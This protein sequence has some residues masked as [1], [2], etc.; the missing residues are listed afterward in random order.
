MALASYFDK[1]ALAAA[2]VLQGYDRAAFEARLLATPVE[3]AFD[4][5]ATRLP[6]AQ[7]TL[8]LAVRLLARLYPRL[9]LTALDEAACDYVAILETQARAINTQLDLRPA[10]AVASLVVGCT[11][12]E[13]DQPVF[14]LGSQNW[15]ARFSPVAPVGSGASLNPFGAGAAACL[16]AAN[17]FRTVFADQLVGGE[18]DPSLSLSLLDFSSPSAN[19]PGPLLP[20]R[21]VVG[22]AV[23]VGLGAVGQGLTW[24][25]ARLSLQGTLHL[26]DGEAV[27]L[28][29]L[30]RYVLTEENSPGMLKTQLAAAALASSGAVV[31]QHRVTWQ[32][33][34]AGQSTWHLPLVLVGVDSAADRIAIQ[35]ALP[36]RLLNV[37]TQ[38]ADLGISRH[39][40]F[41]QQACLTCLYR[42]TG[43]RPSE[44]Q[45]VAQAL[46]LP[47]YE[48]DIRELLYTNA[49]L[50]ATWLER[51]AQAKGLAPQI[52]LPFAGKPIRAF[53][54]QQVCG[55][56][57]LGAAAD[58]QTQ[59]P[60]AFQS[61]LAGLLL[62]AE[63]VIEAQ[64]LRP[65]PLPLLTRLN[66]LRPLAPFLNEAF[67]KT[68]GCICQ[69]E[70]YRDQYTRKYTIPALQLT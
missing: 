15:L 29:N 26:V 65:V 43:L 37:W 30:Q 64:Q 57:L 13:R 54:S 44:S 49:P 3:L 60:M 20:E 51:I 62:A 11:Q 23:V 1:A 45:T 5:A 28:S 32:D 42:A 41:Q 19:D 18:T 67:Q 38:T 47:Q 40:D 46:G 68:A 14:Y 39:L 53:Y 21:L 36:Q 16:G 61:A 8:D 25:L 31:Q 4:G 55:S 35:G 66:L 7:A 27:E 52:L 33:F 24:A 17:V 10:P 48:R 6:E 63:F 22:D 56:L 69:D 2:H 12:L 9:V 70:D 50:D 58:R 59:T 34:L